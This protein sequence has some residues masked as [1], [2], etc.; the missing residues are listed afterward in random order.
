MSTL[1]DQLEKLS[2]TVTGDLNY[3]ITQG[4]L[5][6]NES[7]SVPFLGTLRGTFADFVSHVSSFVNSFKA[8]NFNRETIDFKQL[9]EKLKLVDYSKTR[10]MEVFV[11]PGFHA[12]W[13]EF[14]NFVLKDIMPAVN[15]LEQT[16][17]STN[18]KMAVLLNEPDRMK[19]Q[20]GIRDISTGV[21]LVELDDFDKLKSFF[22]TTGKTA[23]T[24]SGV[25]DRQADVAT[26][27]ALSN[28]LNAEL[29]AV[30]FNAIT[31]LTTRLGELTEALQKVMGREE[32]TELS[33]L[34]SSQLADTFYQLGVTMTAGAVMIEVTK[35]MNDSMIASRD[36]LLKQIG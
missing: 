9:D 22:N 12:H 31:K 23:T 28:R 2:G 33:G 13:V 36:S 5:L 18:R 10:T 29:S 25:V 6:S 7:K 1:K 4:S 8:G 14:F 27:F 16:L 11:P 32:H 21:A 15:V 3:L 19:A 34:V 30:D 26:A 35:Q 24:L 20:S 17:V